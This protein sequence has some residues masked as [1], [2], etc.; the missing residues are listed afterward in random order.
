MNA[1]VTENCKGCEAVVAAPGD[2]TAPA[3]EYNHWISYLRA[4]LVALV[5]AHHAILAY[6]TFAPPA[7]ASLLVE[8]RWWPAFPVADS[9]RWVG[10]DLFAGFN[11]TFLM[12]L[13]F[14]LS[15]LFV[16][17]GL[18]RKGSS[19]F[20]SDRLR[21][22][23]VPFL[24]AAA[25]LAPLAYYPAYLGTL[26]EHSFTGFWE[27]WLALGTWPVGPVWFLSVLL[28]FDA[29]AAMLF[30]G[31]PG[32]GEALGKLVAGPSRRP[33]VFFALLVAVSALAYVPMALQFGPLS[34]TTFGPFA[35]QTSRIV[36]YLVY[37]LFGVAIGASGI[38][39]GL[40]R[41]HGKL[42]R[43]WPLWA[44]AALVF[45]G[46]SVAIAVITAT[47]HPHSP[48]WA[49]AGAFAFVVSCASA[50]LAFLALFLR[51]ARKPTRLFDGL[52]AKSYAVYLVHYAIVNW[53][54]YVLLPVSLPAPAK[55]AIAV[56]AALGLSWAASAAIRRIP[57]VARLV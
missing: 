17:D 26:G 49:A 29:F 4:S 41:P 19:R 14:F 11:D 56:V 39:R 7:A 31:I 37:F 33:A 40:L 22:L 42:A 5:V 57:A 23:G 46:V 10:F 28:L 36:H 45:Y 24:V 6:H 9:A 20:L 44:T 27:Q 18:R 48:S 55:G 16:W 53:L 34:W 51:Y 21:R 25:I 54:L 13:F 15:G 52:S 35:F 12:S 3:L 32:W 38:E 43:R 47:A 1:S 30:A 2:A 8:P 50:S